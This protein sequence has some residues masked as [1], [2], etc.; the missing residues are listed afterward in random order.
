MFS[1]LK[2]ACRNVKR[3]ELKSLKLVDFTEAAWRHN[4]CKHSLH[5]VCSARSPEAREQDHIWPPSVEN[6]PGGSTT[7]TWD[8][9]SNS[10]GGV[11]SAVC[12]GP[13]NQTKLPLTHTGKRCTTPQAEAVH[14]KARDH[15]LTRTGI[16][17]TARSR[18]A[19]KHR[20]DIYRNTRQ[21]PH[22]RQWATVDRHFSFWSCD[23]WRECNGT[24]GFVDQ[25]EN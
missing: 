18:Q 9:H 25:G 15:S 24:S 8:S 17:P 13:I 19:G 4:F 22:Q 3:T 16:M 10:R 20:A 23:V 2:F 6:H 1:D 14:G 11:Q 5:T 7:N 21:L 12:Q